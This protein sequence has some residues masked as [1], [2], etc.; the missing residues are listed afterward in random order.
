VR[1][2]FL[3]QIHEKEVFLARIGN[4]VVGTITL[5]WS[6]PVFWNGASP[7]AGYI[8]KFAVVR[9]YAGRKIGEEMLRWAEK[10]AL[11]AG[12]KYLRLDCLASNS[13]IRAYYEKAGYTYKGD[14]SPAGWRASLYEK[15]L[16][17]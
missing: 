11:M 5:Q 17:E 13:K 4:D 9:A 2:R 8:H 15:P 3:A 12:R 16:S 7:D 14:A 6:D 1:E 10:Q